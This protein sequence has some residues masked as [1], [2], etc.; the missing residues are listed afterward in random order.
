MATNRKIPEDIITELQNY[1][2]EN[3]YEKFFQR[4]EEDKICI[5]EKNDSASL[6]KVFITDI[7]HREKNII[8]WRINL[9]LIV[10]GLSPLQHQSTTETAIAYFEDN[11]LK[12]FF[13][14]LKSSIQEKAGKSSL[15]AIRIKME[16]SMSRFYFLF[17][18]LGCF[19]QV[20]SQTGKEFDIAKFNNSEIKFYGRVFYNR[21]K[22]KQN[23]D[24]TSKS[25][26]VFQGEKEHL[27]CESFLRVEKLYLR[28]YQNPVPNTESFEISFNDLIKNH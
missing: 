18:T 7:P 5:E 23:A 15:E 22:I 28:F 9:E 11:K 21:K 10:P 17:V 16:D 6:K 26:K 13:I 20:N 4:I 1:K 3:T 12:V 19:H 2:E 14:E 27:Q 8:L 24:I 25:Y